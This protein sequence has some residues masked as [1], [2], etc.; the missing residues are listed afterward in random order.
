MMKQS[1]QKP[2]LFAESFDLME[3]VAGNCGLEQ[4]EDEFKVTH[5]NGGQ[6]YIS[7]KDD[8]EWQMF[9]NGNT[10]CTDAAN[11]ENGV[12]ECYNTP[13]PSLTLFAS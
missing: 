10:L 3:H 13:A 9:M 1:Y 2:V 4:Y 6:C 8:P 5:R 11:V 7:Y 12:I